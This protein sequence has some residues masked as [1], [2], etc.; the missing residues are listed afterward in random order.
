MCLHLLMYMFIQVPGVQGFCYGF[1]S[2]IRAAPKTCFPVLFTCLTFVLYVSDCG[3]ACHPKCSGQLPNN[4]GLP[5]ELVDFALPSSA[6]K[7]RQEE[8]E[9]EKVE[10]GAAEKPGSSR[11]TRR[12]DETTKIG[13]VF[14]P[15]YACTM[16]A[17]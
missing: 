14:V 13:K 4:C 2:P 9:E 11:V 10:E 15:K 1:K 6:K 5:A 12:R 8:E 17:M 3:Q 16:H 7:S